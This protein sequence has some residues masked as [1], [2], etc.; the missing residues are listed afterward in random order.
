[1]STEPNR[2]IPRSLDPDYAQTIRARI[3]ARSTADTSTPKGV[4]GPL[5]SCWIWQGPRGVDGRGLM[6]VMG[7]MMGA[8]RGAYL[9]FVGPISDD[10]TTGKTLELDH[11]CRR[12]A[13]AC[14]N[15]DHLEQ[16]TAA[17]NV[18]RR[19]VARTACVHGHPYVEESYRLEQRDGY[20]FR[21]CLICQRI[22][23]RESKR[24]ARARRK[25]T[26]AE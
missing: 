21:R 12:G 19:F 14:V 11:L 25:A 18:A 5:S 2:S 22:A 17:V 6:R 7:V 3:E 4:N 1:M 8:H 15:P 20:R 26:P 24:R 10:P 9:A 23:S 16:V 13:D